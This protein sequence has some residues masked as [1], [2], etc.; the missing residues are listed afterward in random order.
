M[1]ALTLFLSVILP[2][3]AGTAWLRFN[4]RCA[5]LPWAVA[6]GYGH[7]IGIIVLT[8]LMRAA[9]L[10]GL[11]WNFWFLA[12]AL[13]GFGLIPL[14]RARGRLGES[15]ALPD[16]RGEWGGVTPW[17]RWVAMALAAVLLARLTGLLLEIVW[18]P[19]YPWDAWMQWAT[20][21]R[22]WF[23]QGYMT[24]FVEFGD[25]IKAYPPIAFTDPTPGYPATIPLLQVWSALA[26]GRWDDALINLPWFACGVALAF[27]FF[28]QLRAWG[29]SAFIAAVATYLL[30]TLPLVNTH[31]ALAG[32]AELHVSA[33]YGLA[34][35]AFFLWLRDKDV[36]YVC[37]ALLLA[38]ALPLVK[39][40]GVFWLASFLP[41][42]LV[43]VRKRTALIGL[44]C[45]GVLG[46]A[47]LFFLRESGMR[48][49][50]Y[51]LSGDVDVAEVTKALQQN[52]FQMGNWNLLFWL[53]PAMA[54]AAWRRL[55][56][57]PIA[58]MTTMVAF[59]IYFLGIVFYFSIAGDWVSDFT[60]VNRAVF[61]L[62]PLAVFWMVALVERQFHGPPDPPKLA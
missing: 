6:L 57:G 42:Y 1:G 43:A 34:A 36:R 7:F 23:E 4:P 56:E 17:K 48:V 12:L 51:S 35:M 45:L 59:G 24:P 50:A 31:I 25:W 32:Y 27:A 39:K 18:R 55:F 14:V 21:A 44:A 13:A 8:L 3:A 26:L 28:G 9:S 61:H 10:V 52:L 30:M 46:I 41:A 11:K 62:V 47:A 20:K 15:L 60:T 49:F 22:V 2:W 37:L 40:P 5:P 33:M 38:L 16:L 29:T 53:L 58:A 54:L 19:L